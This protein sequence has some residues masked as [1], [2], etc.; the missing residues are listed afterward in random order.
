MESVNEVWKPVAGYEGRYEVS[1]QGR[2]RSL[3]MIGGKKVR[4]VLKPCSSFSN[5]AHTKRKYQH[6][7]LVGLYKEGKRRPF[8]VHILVANSFLP[9]RPRGFQVDHINGDKFDNRAVN[10]QWLSQSENLRKSAYSSRNNKYL[11]TIHL[12]NFDLS[13]SSYCLSEVAERVGVK[14]QKLSDSF[15]YK[16]IYENDEFKVTRKLKDDAKKDVK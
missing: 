7:K 13:Y 14:R 2:V 1:D 5:K 6:Y 15:R 4:N 16:G 3:R 8:H 11:Y 9:A 10:L 12:N